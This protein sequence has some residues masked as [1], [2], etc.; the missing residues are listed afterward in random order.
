MVFLNV[1]K[2]AAVV[3]TFILKML[4]GTPVVGVET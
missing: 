2:V 1:L 3:H 4:W